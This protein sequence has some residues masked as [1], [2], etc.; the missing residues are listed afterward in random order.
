MDL[1]CKVCNQKN[2]NSSLH[3]SLTYCSKCALIS[4]SSIVSHDAYVT[5]NYKEYMTSGL[6]RSVIML[7]GVF[8][9]FSMLPFGQGKWLDFGCGKGHFLST[10]P[11]K[12]IKFGWEIVGNRAIAARANNPNTIII[13]DYLGET[14]ELDSE[15]MDV[16]SLFHVLEHLDDPKL[17]VQLLDKYL[18]KDGKVVIEVPNINSLQAKIAKGN[19]LH[20]DIPNHRT[21]WSYNSLQNFFESHDFKV[22]KSSQISF[23]EGFL[24]MADALFF[25]KSELRIYDRLK[26]AFLKKILMLPVV[27]ISVIIELVAC[28]LSFG[29]V[30]R[31]LLTRK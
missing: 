20:L 13:E 8:A 3:N 14:T 31:I 15:K 30:T 24:G 4:T 25:C 29:G 2:T 1:N 27:F 16:I 17:V 21:H 5:G 7:N 26:G 23:T 9:R 19:W 18:A 22:I 6:E 12:Y 10:L 11:S 28:A